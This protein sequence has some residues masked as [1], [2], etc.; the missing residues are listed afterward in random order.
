MQQPQEDWTKVGLLY[1]LTLLPRPLVPHGFTHKFSLSAPRSSFLQASP[2]PRRSSRQCHYLR[3]L[4][5]RSNHQQ[6]GGSLFRGLSPSV[7]LP[8]KAW[9]LVSPSRARGASDF[10]PA[11]LSGALAPGPGEKARQKM[12]QHLKHP[13]LLPTSPPVTAQF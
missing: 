13:S 10:I 3:K 2:S 7:L 9:H 5:C 12:P 4:L 11:A 6:D 1:C 8:Q